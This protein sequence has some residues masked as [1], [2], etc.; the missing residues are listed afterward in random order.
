MLSLPDAASIGAALHQPLDSDL[1]AILAE[2]HE[3]I[4]A[5][6]LG[7]LTHIVVIQAADTETQ[8]VEAIGWS[9]LVQPI[10][11]VRYGDSDFQPYWA[12]LR[13][14]G[15]WYELIHPIGNDGFAFILLVERSDTVFSAMC[16]EGIRCGS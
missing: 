6:C 12:W 4:T 3:Q 13:D 8:I 9:P 5:Q 16:E 1:H 2:R 7:E 14:L 15:G 11:G 10:D